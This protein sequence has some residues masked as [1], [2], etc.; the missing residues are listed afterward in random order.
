MVFGKGL[1][2]IRRE[3]RVGGEGG[4]MG[5]GRHICLRRG[6]RKKAAKSGIKTKN[7][8][9]TPGEG[10][11]RSKSGAKA[12]QKG[13]KPTVK[14]VKDKKSS[15]RKLKYSSTYHKELKKTGLKHKARAAAQLAVLGL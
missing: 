1:E 4:C 15:L 2:G 9:K 8:T 7:G 3:W 13:K 6:A 14:A 10:T 11:E 5:G 12:P